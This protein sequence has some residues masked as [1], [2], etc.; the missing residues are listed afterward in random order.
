M[1]D[2]LRDAIASVL[3]GCLIGGIVVVQCMPT[4][5]CYAVKEPP[6]VQASGTASTSSPGMTGCISFRSVPPAIYRHGS[7]TLSITDKAAELTEPNIN[8]REAK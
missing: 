6:T 1:P 8:C 4:T 7:V 5:K 2:R 3:V